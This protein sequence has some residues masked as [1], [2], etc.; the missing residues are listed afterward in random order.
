MT[1]IAGIYLGII[2]IIAFGLY[3]L[4]KWKAKNHRWRISEATLFFVALAGGSLG[5]FLGMY[6]FHHKTKHRAFTTGIPIILILQCI[7]LW[8][9]G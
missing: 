9:W 1:G 4:D 8:R 3:G 5:A 2:N 6:I 7:I